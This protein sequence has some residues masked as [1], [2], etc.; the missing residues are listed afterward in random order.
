MNILITVSTYYPDLNGVANVTKYLAEG[1]K[2]LGHNIQI[3]TKLS[4]NRKRN[5]EINGIKVKRFILNFNKFTGYNGEIDEYKKFVS[6]FECDIMI[7]VCTQC[8]TTDVLLPI[9]NKLKMKKILHVHGFSAIKLKPLN[10]SRGIKGF[11]SNLYSYLYWKK[12]YYFKFKK[13]VN[14]YDKII[15][16]TKKD[17]SR[18]YLDKYYKSGKI[19][20]LENAVDD[21]FL[22]NVK[23]EYTFELEKYGI[24]K[25]DKYLVSVA[26][27]SPVKNQRLLLDIFYKVKID[28]NYKLVMVGNTEN[29]KYYNKVLKHFQKLKKE[30]K[31][32]QVIFLTNIEREMI[33]LIIANAK[34]YLVT[35]VSEEFSISIIEAMSQKTPFIST[36][37]GNASE[38]KGGIVVNNGK[39][40]IKELE[41]LLN[42]DEKMIKL[43]LEGYNYVI[44]NCTID[45]AIKRLEYMINN[46]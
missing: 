19:E 29:I 13:Y 9:L 35:S 11:C 8:V 25:D 30:H 41:S 20:V 33:P 21:I 37:V 15:T 3:I 39:Q 16:L 40:M 46:I 18:S 6:N 24:Y 23:D 1:L 4:Q 14:E 42:N 34:V 36:N 17:S 7:N 31:E 44:A 43:G 26:N 22:K 27:F 38:L 10:F 28:E 5:E 2:K 45:K 32:K 12:I